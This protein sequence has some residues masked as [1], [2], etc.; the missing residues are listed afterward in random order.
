MAKGNTGIPSAQ[1]PSVTGLNQGSGSRGYPG[2][3]RLDLDQR[4]RTSGSR[5]V[6]LEDLEETNDSDKGT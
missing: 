6:N 4:P 5:Y 3:Q 1:I 2:N